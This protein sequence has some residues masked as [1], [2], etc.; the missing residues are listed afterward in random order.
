L[1]VVKY[2]QVTQIGE[3]GGIARAAEGSNEHGWF[4]STLVHLGPD[5]RVE[6]HYLVNVAWVPEEMSVEEVNAALKGTTFTN[7][8][9]DFKEET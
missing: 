9:L 4:E 8:D 1:N 7:C 2:Y 6:E 5:A 3:F